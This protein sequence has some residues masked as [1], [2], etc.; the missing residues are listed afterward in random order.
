MHPDFP[1][2]LTSP[3]IAPISRS[4]AHRFPLPR[5]LPSFDTNAIAASS[6]FRLAFPYADGEA[7]RVEMAYLDRRFDTDRAN[8]G[9]VAAKPKR[10]RPKKA[11]EGE[12][13]TA[14]PPGKVL[15]EGSTGVRLQ[16][17]WLPCE[18]ALPIAE[19]YGLTLYAKPLIES[20]AITVGGTVQLVDPNAPA[21]VSATPS[22]PAETKTPGTPSSTR[23]RARTTKAAAADESGAEDT[24]T[25]T[26]GKASRT[27]TKR[28]V[29]ADG[30]E[31]TTVTK[32]TT[33]IEP[34]V[35]M[36][37]DEIDEQIKKSRELAKEVQSTK[38]SPSAAATKSRKR[39]ASNQR[40]TA[41]LDPLEDD[42]SVNFV[43]RSIR[44]GTRVARRRPIATSAGALS[45]AAAAGVGAL[46]W[47][48][49]GQVDVAQQLLQQGLSAMQGFFF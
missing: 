19:E 28:A 34:A 42:S 6:M 30:T 16:G 49:G 46:A 47:F 22:T 11:K 5:P 4:L 32:T 12:E 36:T 13:E 45:V 48:T 33:T 27:R 15:P 18:D 25:S 24:T 43:S 21:A 14:T 8:G 31:E 29:K 38:A 40:P 37:Q 17:T 10:G 35:G 3:D 9:L 44:R 7:E 39:R 1:L 2:F 20:Q 26:P 41:D 23:K